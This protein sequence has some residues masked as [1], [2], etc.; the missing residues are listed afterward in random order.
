MGFVRLSNISYNLGILS[1]NVCGLNYKLCGS[2][3]TGIRF[4]RH[5]TPFKIWLNPCPVGSSGM[6]RF[7]QG[8]AGSVRH[9]RSL[10]PLP[11]TGGDDA[12][13]GGLRWQCCW[14]MPYYV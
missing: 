1:Y 5:F 7:G 6:Q 2:I 8:V 4:R 9:E 3:N 12:E 14:Y 13:A 10:P 11:D